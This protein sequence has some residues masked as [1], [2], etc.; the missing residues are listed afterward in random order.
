MVCI[1]CGKVEFVDNERKKFFCYEVDD[2]EWLSFCQLSFCTGAWC[3]E[4]NQSTYFN[5]ASI[6]FTTFPFLSVL[7]T[8]F[9]INY[10]YYSQHGKLNLFIQSLPHLA[11]FLFE[12]AHKPNKL[13]TFP[14]KF[15]C[16]CNKI[17]RTV[18]D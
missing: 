10:I 18:L 15:S 1:K 8:I 16:F 14:F 5:K 2:D 4:T 12:P 9:L 7:H 11:T 3:C 6:P 13:L 17:D